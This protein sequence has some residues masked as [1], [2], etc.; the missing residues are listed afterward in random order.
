MF[1]Y[2]EEDESKNEKVLYPSLLPNRD[3]DIK[4]SL[5]EQV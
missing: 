4:K 5:I 1:N 2:D 3:S